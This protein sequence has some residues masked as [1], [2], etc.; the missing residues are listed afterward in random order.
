MKKILLYI[1]LTICFIFVSNAQEIPQEFLESLPFEAGNG[2]LNDI[3]TSHENFITVL[4]ST[5]KEELT[6]GLRRSTDILLVCGVCAVAGIFKKADDDPKGGKI[7]EVTGI[8]LLMILTLSDAKSI[9]TECKNAIA[10]I[11]VFSKILLPL[12]AMWASCA[13]KP[14]SAVGITSGAMAY[15]SVCCVLAEKLIF[16]LI[17]VYIIMKCTGMAGDNK[18]AVGMADGLKNALFFIVKLC[19]MGISFYLTLSGCIT[20]AG[21]GAAIKAAKAAV[22]VLPGIGSA[23]A[24]VT[25]SVI[26]GAGIIRNSIGVLGV[27]AVLYFILGPFTKLFINMI[28]FRIAG[29]ISSAFTSDVISQAITSISDGYSIALGMLA[30]AS[31]G[32]V[33]SVAVSIIV[34][35]G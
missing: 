27:I 32:V 19:L 22:S 28:I 30:A 5:L 13:G 4:K 10:D 9:I 20:S 26:A 35:G 18:I 12:L 14:M 34:L 31:G 21:D 1:M 8:C 33:M 15:T 24:G 25:E 2:D 16:I 6:N 17:F 11:G 23:V 7:V 3:K 29:I